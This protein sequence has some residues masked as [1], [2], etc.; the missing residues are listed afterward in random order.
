MEFSLTKQLRFCSAYQND[1]HQIIMLWQAEREMDSNLT[2]RSLNMLSDNDEYLPSSTCNDE[3]SRDSER[4]SVIDAV[5][6][7]GKSMD[8]VLL[9]NV[10]PLIECP[11]VPGVECPEVPVV[12]CPEVPVVECPE[13]PV[14]ECSPQEVCPTPEA[15][16]TVVCPD[17]ECPSVDCPD[18]PVQTS[19]APEVECPTPDQCSDAIE[20]KSE[21]C[22]PCSEELPPV[23]HVECPT[24]LDCPEVTTTPEC[25]KTDSMNECPRMS[26]L[27]AC[28]HEECSHASMAACEHVVKN[29]KLPSSNSEYNARVD[30]ATAST[31]SNTPSSSSNVV[32]TPA[33]IDYALLAT[34]SKIL[35]DYTSRTYVPSFSLTYPLWNLLV[36]KY[37]VEIGIVG[38]PEEA[39]SIPPTNGIET[40][41]LGRCWAIEVCILL[42][43]FVPLCNTHVTTCVY[44]VIKDN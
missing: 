27:V 1:A 18:C 33:E 17:V 23:D 9:A 13:V 39:L 42:F 21:V 40:V 22:P 20:C 38:R 32:Q 35:Y 34:G 12:E 15:C 41:V 16:E 44:R 6:S 26:A 10:P 36:N 28:L 37:H 8:S 4:K 11:E 24:Q 2:L 7:L 29:L 5:D 31:N 3:S 19:T 43:C 30:P 14:V 25:E